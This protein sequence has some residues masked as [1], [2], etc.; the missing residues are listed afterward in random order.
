MQYAPVRTR[1]Q[2]L[3]GGARSILAPSTPVVSQLY[4]LGKRP[5]PIPDNARATPA[6]TDNRAWLRQR[7]RKTKVVNNIQ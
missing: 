3:I 1:L 2:G 5:G 7:K 6:G 4:R